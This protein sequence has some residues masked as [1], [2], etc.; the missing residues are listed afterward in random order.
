MKQ[1]P[2]TRMLMTFCKVAQYLSFQHAAKEL[3]LTKSAVSHQIRSIESIVEA[4]LFSRTGR[5]V[6]LT[7]AG[8]VFLKHSVNALREIDKAHEKIASIRGTESSTIRLSSLPFFSNVVI[9]PNLH[10]LKKDHPNLSLSLGSSHDYA[11]FDTG[12]VDVAIRF[13]RRH[14]SG[15]KF[16]PL[17]EVKSTPVCNPDLFKHSYSPDRLASHPLIHFSFQPKAWDIWFSENG[18]N[19]KPASEDLWMD[20]VPDAIQAV[21][22]GLGSAL[23]MSPLIYGHPG[24]GETLISPFPNSSKSYDLFLVTKTEQIENTSFRAFE[25]WLRQSIRSVNKP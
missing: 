17:M 12:A 18:I 1:Y 11:D 21:Q 25:K 9:I 23:A 20:N 15:L 16:K 19:R 3:G 2:S 7:E 14:Q 22:A 24:Y 5:K 13:G 4:R 6:I 10:R 8:H